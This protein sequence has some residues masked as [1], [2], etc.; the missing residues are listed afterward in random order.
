MPTLFA[1]NAPLAP[2][3]FVG[4]KKAIEHVSG[5]LAEYTRQSTCLAGGPL[6][7]KTS[8]L[9]YLAQ[10]DSSAD[11]PGLKDSCRVFF[12]GFSVGVSM[13]PSG[14]W[15]GILRGLQANPKSGALQPLLTD[16]LAKAKA[17]QID[18]YDLEDVFDG[19][20]E[21]K[22]PV[23]IFINNFEVL[24]QSSHF[25]PPNDFFHQVRSLGQREPRGVSFVITTYR[26]VLDLWDPSKGASPF[27]NVFANFSVGLL[28]EDEI[29]HFL[30]IGFDELGL[31]LDADVEKVIMEGS[32]GHPY[33]VNYLAQLCTEC[34]A[35]GKTIEG[36]MLEEAFQDPNGPVINLI[37]QIRGSLTPSEKA[38]LDTLET[39]PGKLTETQKTYLRDLRTYGLLPP[40]LK[41]KL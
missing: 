29:R 36:K 18:V 34:L 1:I 41:S 39:N 35:A 40:G 14:F 16:K 26:Q 6:T 4:R 33:L 22:M 8:L 2:D 20:A 17:D 19:F 32:E 23:I 27:Y 12:E 15:A 25:W 37:R 13:L 10:A 30:K 7:G 5:R 11:L 28:E 38:L 31:P 9:R 21:A 3:R 24:L